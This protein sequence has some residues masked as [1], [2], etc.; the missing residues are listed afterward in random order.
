MMLEAQRTEVRIEQAQVGV[1]MT[2][3]GQSPRNSITAT[4]GARF[5]LLSPLSRCC[6]QPSHKKRLASIEAEA[7]LRIDI[8][9]L[10]RYRCNVTSSR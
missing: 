5:L 3:S 6:S 2:Y 8:I 4:N 7:V 10:C 1:A 9:P